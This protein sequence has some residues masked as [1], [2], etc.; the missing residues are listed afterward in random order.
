MSEQ[1]PKT[2]TRRRLLLTAGAAAGSTAILASTLPFRSAFAA[3][4]PQV[5]VGMFAPYTGSAA[6]FGA[7]YE[8]GVRLAVDQVNKAA[9]KILG[10]PIIKQLLAVDTGTLPA[11]GIAAVKRLIQGHRVPVVIGGWSSGVTVAVATSATLPAGVLQVGYGA[12]SPLITVLPKDRTRDLLFRT[13]ASDA[14][15]GRVAALLA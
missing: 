14:L 5:K 7:F 1:D 9:E 8:A 2:I 13:T 12:T 4:P 10:G 15:Q 6:E 11:P 3:A